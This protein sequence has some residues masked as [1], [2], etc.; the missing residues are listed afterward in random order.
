MVEIEFLNKTK[1]DTTKWEK[2][3]KAIFDSS[4]KILKLKHDVNLAITFVGSKE[5]IKINK[6]FRKKDYTPDVIS[7]PIKM[8]LKEI[9]ALG[10]Q[11][12]GD[13]FICIDEAKRKSVKYEHTL[14]QEMAFLFV[15]GF[16]HLL[17]YDHELSEHEEKIMFDLQEKILKINHINYIIKFVEEDYIKEGL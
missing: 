3:S 1:K 11:E 14:D 6:D 4:I 7:F 16:L 10:Y 17:G 15:H 5:A 9:K 2:L 8:S 13:I 12:I